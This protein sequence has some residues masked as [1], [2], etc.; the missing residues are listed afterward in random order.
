MHNREITTSSEGFYKRIKKILDA[1]R[2][3]VYRT[4][5]F[6]M[7]QAYWHIGREIVEEEQKGEDWAGYGIALLKDLSEDSLINKGKNRT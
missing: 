1:A 6:E 5:N 7:V 4:A 3:R 2:E